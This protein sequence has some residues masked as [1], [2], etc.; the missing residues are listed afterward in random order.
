MNLGRR[1]DKFDVR[2]R[3]FER[4][5]KSVERSNGKHMNLVDDIHS[6][7]TAC[8][9]KSGFISYI[10]DVVNAVITGGVDFNNVKNCARL[11]SLTDF[12]FTA[13]ITV[14][15]V[16]AVDRLGKNFCTGGFPRA[17]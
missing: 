1:K 11:N 4:F 7:F 13:G 16:Q 3:L 14:H 12:T 10:S 9:C 17:S 2:R 15:G 5:Q 8:R 6:V